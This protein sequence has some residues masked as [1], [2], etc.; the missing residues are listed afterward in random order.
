MDSAW[1]RGDDDWAWSQGGGAGMGERKDGGKRSPRV[2]KE[3]S[4]NTWP[5]IEGRSP[6]KTVL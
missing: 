5:G 1:A 6:G 2:G 4:W 3:L